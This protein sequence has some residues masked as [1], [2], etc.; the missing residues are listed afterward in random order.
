MAITLT[1]TQQQ[2]VKPSSYLVVHQI[3]E[4][5]GIADLGLHDN[6]ARVFLMT[7]TG[8]MET[9]LRVC[10]PKDYVTYQPYPLE[11][12]SKLSKFLSADLAEVPLGAGYKL[13]FEV[14]SLP[15]EPRVVDYWDTEHNS[16]TEL[17]ECEIVGNSPRMAVLTGIPDTLPSVSPDGGQVPFTL[18]DSLDNVVVEGYGAPTRSADGSI[19]RVNVCYS[20][21]SSAAAARFATASVQAELT[22]L[23]AELNASGAAF[24]QL[25]TGVY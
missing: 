2:V 13:K 10:T 11:D 6:L 7:N 21:H 23:V 22:S 4:V 12:P 15:N 25:I 9:L 20:F 14:S 19:H 17:W 3:T 8:G 18:L 5:A 24:D 1:L 16:G